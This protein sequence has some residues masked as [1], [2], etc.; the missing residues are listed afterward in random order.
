MNECKKGKG[1]GGFYPSCKKH[2]GDY[3]HLYKNDQWGFFPGGFCP[4]PMDPI[5][6]NSNTRKLYI[7][8]VIGPKNLNYRRATKEQQN[9]AYIYIYI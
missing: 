5:K 3:I 4:Y 1:L 6:I 8:A 9:A 2:G 7:E